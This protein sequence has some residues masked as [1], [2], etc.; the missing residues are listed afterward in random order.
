MK[1]CQST[2]AVSPQNTSHSINAGHHP[3]TLTLDRCHLDP[4]RPEL[5]PVLEYFKF[6]KNISFCVHRLRPGH[7]I[8]THRDE[9]AY[10]TKKFNVELSA[11]HRFIVFLEDHQDGHILFINKFTQNSYRSGYVAGWAGDT[12]HAALNF[13]LTDR[14]TLQ[15][16]GTK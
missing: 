5:V 3:A 1:K 14:Y 11:V 12:P 13:G 6:L 16:T 8:P 9:Y 15:V 7:Y 10:Y 4:D 2:P